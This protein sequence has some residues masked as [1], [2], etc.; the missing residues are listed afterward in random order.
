MFAPN[1]ISHTN[2]VLF[3]NGRTALRLSARG[4]KIAIVKYLAG[5]C[6]ANVNDTS[7][8]CLCLSSNCL[9][10]HFIGRNNSLILL[11]YFMA[12]VCVS[13]CMCLRVCMIF[14]TCCKCYRIG[15]SS[16]HSFMGTRTYK[17]IHLYPQLHA[18]IFIYT[19]SVR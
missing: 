13:L 16:Y 12:T 5:E 6:N 14:I 18:C 10:A 8:V 11:G 4:D 15:E 3:Q 9:R 1:L 2:P 7:K 19:C 17:F